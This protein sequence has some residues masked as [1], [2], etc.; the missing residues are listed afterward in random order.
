M[1]KRVLITG[2][3]GSNQFSPEVGSVGEVARIL[4]RIYAA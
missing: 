1:G 2:G 4:D 3:A